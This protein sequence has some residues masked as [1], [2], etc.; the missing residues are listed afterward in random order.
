MVGDESIELLSRVR[1]GDEQA[2]SDLF[3]RYVERLIKLARSR[4][5]AK[6]Q[7]RVDP[8][9][10][11]QSAYRSFFSHA[12]DGRY[13]LHKSGDLW[14]LLAAITVNKVAVTQIRR[15]PTTQVAARYS[16]GRTGATK[17]FRR[18]RVQTS[19]RNAIATPC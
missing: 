19:S 7:R 6:L 13:Q 10:V 17:T 2:A 3:D 12:Q 8:E 4:L 5:S 16:R 18:F 1:Q 9:D 15:K 11:V 14:R